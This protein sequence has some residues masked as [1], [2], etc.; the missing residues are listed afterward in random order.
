M[1]ERGEVIVRQVGMYDPNRPCGIDLFPERADCRGQR[2]NRVPTL[3]RAIIGD[4]DRLR[5]RRQWDSAGRLLKQPH[6]WRQSGGLD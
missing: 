2:S 5:R 6:C 3:R 4:D 1:E